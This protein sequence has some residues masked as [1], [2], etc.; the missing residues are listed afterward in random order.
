MDFA[1]DTSGYGLGAV[2]LHSNGPKNN[3]LHTLQVALI[4]D[5]KPRASTCGPKMRSYYKQCSTPVVGNNQF[6]FY[7]CATKKHQNTNTLSLFPVTEKGESRTV[8]YRET[9]WYIEYSYG[10]YI[11]LLKKWQMQ[12]S[13]IELSCIEEFTRRGLP[14]TQPNPNLLHS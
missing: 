8:F 3:P 12:K 13:A 5:Y 14:C 7:H 6:D 9:D 10:T 1:V 4:T 2:P 11:W